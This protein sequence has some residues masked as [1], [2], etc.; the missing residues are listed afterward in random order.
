MKI[1][2]LLMFIIILTVIFASTTILN[3]FFPNEKVSQFIKDLET[4]GVFVALITFIIQQRV[5]QRNKKTEF[6]IQL[7]NSF[8]QNERFMNTYFQLYQYHI[9]NDYD[10]SELSQQSIVEYLAYFDSIAIAHENKLLEINELSKTFSYYFFIAVN[11]PIVQEKELVVE[12]EYYPRLYELYDCLYKNEEKYGRAI[13]MEKYALNNTAK[14]KE[15][16]G[17]YCNE[18]K[19]SK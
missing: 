19:K 12:G 9:N 18:N 15:I 10:L 4:L 14:Y 13:I 16:I 7:K 17:I 6:F 11:N 2:K 5:E 8:L 1:T 3:V